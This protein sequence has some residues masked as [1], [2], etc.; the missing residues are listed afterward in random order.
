[1]V[2]EVFIPKVDCFR[3]AFDI[4]LYGHFFE[5][6]SII[7][8]LHLS[9]DSLD[10]SLSISQGWNQDGT[11]TFRL[12]FYLQ[13]LSWCWIIDCK[14]HLSTITVQ[15]RINASTLVFRGEYLISRLTYSHFKFEI[16]LV[17]LGESSALTWVNYLKFPRNDVAVSGVLWYKWLSYQLNNVLASYSS[18]SA[19]S[20]TY[21]WV[22][23]IPIVLNV[24]LQPRVISLV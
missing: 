16:K 6:V 23:D 11:L 24:N 12:L 15:L 7:S 22:S 4:Q 13:E 18:V 10:S 19:W 21:R 9:L 8:K 20:H 2:C 1:V 3:T 17:G 5:D 14:E